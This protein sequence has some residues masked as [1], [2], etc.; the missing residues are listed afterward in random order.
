MTSSLQVPGAGARRATKQPPFIRALFVLLDRLQRGRLTITLPN[1]ARAEFGGPAPGAHADIHILDWRMARAVMLRADIGLGEA[2]RDGWFET[3]D[4]TKLLMLA[5]ENAEALE[6]AFFGS[7]FATFFHRLLHACNLNSKRGARKNIAAH[8]DLSN[9]FYSLWLDPSMT[10]SSA[11][12]AGNFE[13]ELASAQQTKYAAILAALALRGRETVLEIG[14]GWGGFAEHLLRHTQA[15][16]HGITLSK[17][18]LDFARRRLRQHA[19][20]ERTAIALQDYRD[21]G[22]T[23]DRIV[24]IEM[25]E[26]V[27]ERYWPDY[28]AALGRLLR[29][30]GIAVVQTITIDDA[31]FEGYRRRTD[32]IQQYIFPG[33]MLPSRSA[34]IHAA[35]CAGLKV[36][37]MRAQNCAAIAALGFDDALRRLWRF[38]LCF[39]EA[40][41]QAK[42]TDVVQFK[43]EHGG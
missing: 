32:F 35:R 8:Y 30:G 22:G 37:E 14:C 10:Y 26:A 16:L 27:G 18:Q 25:F 23:F 13:Q 36:S 3:S 38:Y 43:I 40:G 5:T 4:L 28:F 33:G 39:C 29:P 21:T 2:Y 19:G 15:Q 9:P 6:P 31:V 1:G 20:A 7:R 42:R 41:F 12:F 11:Y 24:S 17:A 34:F